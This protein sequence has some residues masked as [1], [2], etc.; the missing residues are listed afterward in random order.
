[1]KARKIVSLLK[2]NYSPDNTEKFDEVIIS[3]IEDMVKDCSKLIETRKCRT[4]LA[5]R[6]CVD[7]VNTR[8]LAVCRLAAEDDILPK[9]NED[10]LKAVLAKENPKLSS[11]YQNELN[12]VNQAI[13]REE[14]IKNMYIHKVMPFDELTEDNIAHEILLICYALGSYV[15]AGL[16]ITH[17]RPLARRAEFLKHLKRVGISKEIITKFEED[18][19]G[20]MRSIM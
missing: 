6:K 16:D 13:E 2:S 9:L 8:W 3:V 18:P 7:E 17:L 4:T 15:R 11:I 14:A 1:M 20:Y 5:M 10:G 12:K 19:D